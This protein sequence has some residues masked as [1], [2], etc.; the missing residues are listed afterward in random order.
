MKRYGKKKI[1]TRVPKHQNCTICHPE[2]KSTK[3]RAR[4]E[5]KKDSG[6]GAEMVSTEVTK[7]R[8]ARCGWSGP[9]HQPDQMQ[10]R[11]IIVTSSPFKQQRKGP[12]VDCLGTESRWWRRRKVPCSMRGVTGSVEC[13]CIRSTQDVAGRKPDTRVEGRSSSTAGPGF[14]SRQL[15]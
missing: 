6:N 12:G 1:R 11:T 10:R 15:H 13:S 4:R 3:K 5:G 9:H 8:L 2:Q 14:E 7:E